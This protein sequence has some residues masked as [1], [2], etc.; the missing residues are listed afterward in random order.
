MCSD[1]DGCDDRRGRQR[2]QRKQ[3][4]AELQETDCCGVNKPIPLP[5]E[6]FSEIADS[7]A[8]DSSAS[9]Y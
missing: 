8:R 6:M 2:R 7:S 1:D 4:R 5:S 9:H 3:M